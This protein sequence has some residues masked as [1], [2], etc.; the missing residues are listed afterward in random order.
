MGFRK[1]SICVY[2]IVPLQA[3]R[4]HV[5]GVTRLHHDVTIPALP[6][7]VEEEESG[8]KWRREQKKAEVDLALYRWSG[9][10]RMTEDSSPENN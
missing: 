8:D 9:R 5:L 4:I 2:E 1:I 7:P 10:N 6:L 3:D